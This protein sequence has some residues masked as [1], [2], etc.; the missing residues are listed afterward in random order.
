M[1][2]V[3]KATRLVE[4]LFSYYVGH[5]GEVPRSTAP[6]PTATTRA[7]CSD[8]IAG[9]TDRFAKSQFQNLF[10][11][12]SLH[13]YGEGRRHAAG[14]RAANGSPS[15]V[16]RSLTRLRDAAERRV[17]VLEVGSPGAC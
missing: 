15:A 8:Y 12:H 3:H 7:P 16:A 2:E 1:E 17:P 10:V 9:M 6:S 4:S 13:F 14:K 11:P 5:V